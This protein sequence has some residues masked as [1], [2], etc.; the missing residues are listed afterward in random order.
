MSIPPVGTFPVP[1][2]VPVALALPSLKLLPEV[3]AAAGT[4]NHPQRPA[5]FLVFLLGASL[6]LID[7]SMRLSEAIFLV[8]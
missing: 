6:M 8:F 5:H 2:S 4:L 7:L 1:S 3:L